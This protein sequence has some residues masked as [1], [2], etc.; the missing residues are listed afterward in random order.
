MLP[1]VWPRS[2]AVNSQKINDWLQIAGLAGVIGSL[3]FVGL[4]LKQAQAIALS[5]NY[6]SRTANTI[7]TNVGAMS[8]P[9]FLSGMAKVYANSAGELTMRE[10][11]AVELN[12]GTL[13]TMFENNH[14]QYQAGFL[15]EE[16]WQRNLDEMQCLLTVPLF[17]EIV[18]GWSFRESFGAVISGIVGGISDDA[19]NCYTYGWEYP[20]D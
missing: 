17:R 1:V 14:L 9:E 15:N 16:H 18:A 11:I 3:I 10:A 2:I 19:I 6:Q 13:M 12:V 5:D 20:L 4:Q 8:S 7:A